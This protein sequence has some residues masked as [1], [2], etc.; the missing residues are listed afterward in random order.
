MRTPLQVGELEQ[1]MLKEFATLEIDPVEGT[2][3]FLY[4]ML[5]R[6]DR[7]LTPTEIRGLKLVIDQMDPIGV[8]P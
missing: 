7:L 1:I 2:P 5:A 3:A 4:L 8:T 6:W